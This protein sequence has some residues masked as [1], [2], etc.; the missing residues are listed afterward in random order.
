V[1]GS[2]RNC[3][4]MRKPREKKGFCSGEDRNRTTCKFPGKKPVFQNEAA[5]NLTRAAA[6]VGFE[7]V[8]RKKMQLSRVAERT[9]IT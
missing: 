1:Q 8:S 3:P 2:Q 4:D 6:S 5:K 7:I 9:T